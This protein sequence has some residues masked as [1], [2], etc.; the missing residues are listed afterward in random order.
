MSL[1]SMWGA[2]R[3]VVTRAKITQAAMGSIRPALQVTGYAGEIY[4]GIPLLLPYGFNAVPNVGGDVLILRIAGVS[5]HRVALGGDDPNVT[6]SD[7]APGEVGLRANGQQIV[8]RGGGIQILADGETLRKLMT[9]VAMT[10]Y[11][12]HTH[13]ST[14]APPTQQMN[15]AAHLTG[16]F[17]A[18]GA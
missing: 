16:A 4:N 15:A 1:A 18:G 12:T 9:E 10:V 8:L 7:L 3:S 2:I 11:N 17:K 14:G 6:I 5:D 13:A